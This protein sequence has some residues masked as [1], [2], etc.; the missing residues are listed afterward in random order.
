MVSARL[1]GASSRYLLR[2]RTTIAAGHVRSCKSSCSD[3]LYCYPSGLVVGNSFRSGRHLQ[4]QIADIYQGIPGVPSKKNK[5]KS[6][7]ALM[8]LCLGLCFGSTASFNQ[9]VG[10]CP[11]ALVVMMMTLALLNTARALNPKLSASTGTSACL[12]APSPRPSSGD[13]AKRGGIIPAGHASLL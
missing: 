3:A 1:I 11:E 10:Y 5:N 13:S 7:T 9:K 12:G 6:Y 2:A 4:Y 8:L